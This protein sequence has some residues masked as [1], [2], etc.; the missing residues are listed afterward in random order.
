MRMPINNS[1]KWWNADI[2]DDIVQ[3][4][5][6]PRRHEIDRLGQL[7]EQHHKI[8]KFSGPI[9]AALIQAYCWGAADE[10]KRHGRS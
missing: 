7:I 1:D 6:I 5:A 10:R 9:R 4:I 2:P 8:K 3:N